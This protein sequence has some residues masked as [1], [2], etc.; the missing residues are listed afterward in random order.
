MVQSNNFAEYFSL[1]KVCL[2]G[3]IDFLWILLHSWMLLR[4]VGST[5]LQFRFFVFN[6]FYNLSIDEF[7][8]LLSRHQQVLKQELLFSIVKAEFN[9]FILLT[10]RPYEKDLFYFLDILDTCLPIVCICFFTCYYS[11]SILP[12]I[13]VTSESIPHSIEFCVCFLPLVT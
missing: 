1:F 2:H 10:W 9:K 8:L 12:D 5:R 7:Q 6:F 11:W 3:H 13:A 4:N